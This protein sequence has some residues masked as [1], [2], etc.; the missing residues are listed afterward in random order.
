MFRDSSVVDDLHG[1][2]VADPYRWLEDPDSAQTQACEGPLL[3]GRTIRAKY[4]IARPCKH[5]ISFLKQELSCAEVTAARC[6]AR[7]LASPLSYLAK[8]SAHILQQCML[9]GRP[10]ELR[11]C[12]EPTEACPSVVLQLL[13]RRMSSPRESCSSVAQE[14]SSSEQQQQMKQ[15]SCAAGSGYILS[16]QESLQLSKLACSTV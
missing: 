15:P 3:P 11:T 7:I 4:F 1:L 2:K 12:C 16:N 9:S 6:K 8:G 14:S 13:R 10:H 5:M